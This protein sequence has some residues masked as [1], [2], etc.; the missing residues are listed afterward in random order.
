MQQ[1]TATKSLRVLCSCWLP[2]R[3]QVYWMNKSPGRE[4]L[5]YRMCLV[6]LLGRQHTIITMNNLES[7]HYFLLQYL[8][9]LK[10]EA[11]SNL[12]SST[13]TFK[14]SFQVWQAHRFHRRI[15]DMLQICSM[16]QYHSASW[17]K[18][19]CAPIKSWGFWEF[20]EFWEK[21]FKYLQKSYSYILNF[22]KGWMTKGVVLFS[23]Q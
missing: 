4:E 3:K 16:L 15:C 7:S 21:D 11:C 9:T 13:H 8:W 12:W 20:W 19:S 17:D 10:N 6:L 5:P 14:A 2:H 1:N 18:T 22:Q 23:F